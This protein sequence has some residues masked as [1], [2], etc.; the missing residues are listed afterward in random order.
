MD[1]GRPQRGV[2]EDTT[3]LIK[4]H[5]SEVGEYEP[6]LTSQYVDEAGEDGDPYGHTRAKAQPLERKSTLTVAPGLIPLRRLSSAPSKE[7]GESSTTSFKFERHIPRA[8]ANTLGPLFVLAY[9]LLVIYEYL[10]RPAVQGV[11]LSRAINANVVFFFW[12]ILSIFILDWAKSAIAGFEAAAL[13]KPRLAPSS[14][15]HL[16]WHLERNWGSIGGWYKAA[17]YSFN[18]WSG[19]IGRKSNAHWDGPGLLWC[20]LALSSLLFFIAVPLLG[21]TMNLADGVRLSSEN[22]VILGP[23]QNTFDDRTNLEVADLAR[24]TWRQGLSTSPVYPTVFYAAENGSQSFSDSYFD[25][26]IQEIYIADNTSMPSPNRNVTYFSGPRVATRAHGNAWGLLSSISCAPANIYTGLDLVKVTSKSN[27]SAPG[28]S[29]DTFNNLPLLFI[30]SSWYF[31]STPLAIYFKD[32]SFGI[33]FEYLVAI[34]DSDFDVDNDPGNP[35][36]DD[37][38]KQPIHGAFEIAIWQAQVPGFDSNPTLEAMAKSPFVESSNGSLGYGVR[39]EGSSSTGFANLDAMKRTFSDFTKAPSQLAAKA[40]AA[41]N[42]NSPLIEFPGI[43]SINWLVFTALTKIIPGLAITPPSCV[44]NGISPSFDPTCNLFYSANLATGGI[45]YLA[46]ITKDGFTGPILRQSV[47]TP[48]RMTLAAYKIFGQTAAAMMA[49][50]PGN[51][52]TDAL[53]GVV[54]ATDLVAG[55]IPWQLVLALLVAWVLVTAVPQL[56]TFAEKRWSATLDAFELFRFG[57]EYR[58]AVQ[59]FESNEAPENKV[60]RQLPGMVGDLESTKR[61]G[62]IGLSWQPADAE[63]EYMNNRA[64]ARK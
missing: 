60:L 18:Y 45:P 64:E 11:I 17:L 24:N 20:Y 40:E 2:H 16:S 14:A 32:S 4:A 56:W 25:D 53:K 31:D 28:I 54:P 29:S 41:S 48:A 23:N 12:V 1:L 10:L 19:K 59:R 57:A 62:F 35:E 34:S 22:V 50:G 46:N 9:F 47:I 63:K 6:S 61:R 52:T 49:Q 55:P 44:P 58:D 8:M 3:S 7:V 39:C 51:W 42:N 5:R 43:M 36:Y 27:W 37:T 30:N 38:S 26:L 21:L 33:D 13:M 15:I